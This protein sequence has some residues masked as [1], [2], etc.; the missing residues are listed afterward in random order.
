[1]NFPIEQVAMG[2]FT[3]LGAVV[4]GIFSVHTTKVGKKLTVIEKKTNENRSLIIDNEIL[5]Q[6]VPALERKDEALDKI[7]EILDNILRAQTLTGQQLKSMQIILEQRCQALEIVKV[8]QSYL[9]SKDIH[10]KLE[11]LKETSVEDDTKKFLDLI[12]KRLSNG[13]EKGGEL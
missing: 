1:M 12:V 4:T 6:L 9:E 10:S 8:L 11:D 7:A 5:E 3:L 2:I 13:E